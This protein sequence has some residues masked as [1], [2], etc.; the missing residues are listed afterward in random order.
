MATTQRYRICTLDP[1]LLTLLTQPWQEFGSSC[2]VNP[3]SKHPQ[4]NQKTAQKMAISRRKMLNCVLIHFQGKT[5]FSSF[6]SFIFFFSQNCF[7]LVRRKKY[8]LAKCR[9]D[10]NR[11][12]NRNR[13]FDKKISFRRKCPQKYEK[14]VFVKKYD[15][16]GSYLD[17]NVCQKTCLRAGCKIECFSCG[18]LDS[19]MRWNCC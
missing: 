5:F 8:D 13:N 14:D 9:L 6:P 12:A 16:E 3:K 18:G 2:S 15:W 4:E 1:G 10:K 11:I 19:K 7:R 17:E